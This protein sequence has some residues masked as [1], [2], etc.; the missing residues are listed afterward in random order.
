[1]QILLQRSAGVIIKREKFKV[2]HALLLRGRCYKVGQLL[3][4][5]AVQ[6]ANQ[7]NGRGNRFWE[8]PSRND[9]VCLLGYS[10]INP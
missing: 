7:R 2:L 6:K 5:N 9:V 10:F 8:L 1:M 4:S 3:K